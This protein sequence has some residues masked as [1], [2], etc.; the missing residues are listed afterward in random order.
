MGIGSPTSGYG[1]NMSK[2][3]TGMEVGNLMNMKL[4]SYLKGGKG[5]WQQGFGLLPVEGQH[6]KPE[7]VPITRGCFTIERRTWRV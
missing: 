5:I 7:T 2:T 3:V 6:V 1:G 4:A